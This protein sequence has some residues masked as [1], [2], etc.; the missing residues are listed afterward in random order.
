MSRSAEA[1]IWFLLAR[2]VVANP[3]IQ[4]YQGP[5]RPLSGRDPSENVAFSPVA[6]LL[7]LSEVR[8]EFERQAI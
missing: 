5:E 6:S 4:L 1:T 3:Q 2:T 7:T 8:P